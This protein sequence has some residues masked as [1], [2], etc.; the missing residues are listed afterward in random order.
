MRIKFLLRNL[1]FQG[2]IGFGNFRVHKPPSSKHKRG[3]GRGGKKNFLSIASHPL[4]RAVSSAC[5]PRRNRHACRVR[6]QIR[7]QCVNRGVATALLHAHGH[8][9]NVVKIAAQFPS[10]AG[11]GSFRNSGVAGGNSSSLRLRNQSRGAE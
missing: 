4:L 3:G 11:L 8:K 10:Q 1:R 2:G 7:N 9:H 5:G 6:I